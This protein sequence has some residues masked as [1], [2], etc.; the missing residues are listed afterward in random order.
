MPCIISYE[1]QSPNGLCFIIGGD[2]GNIPLSRSMP[3]A[4]R[5]R[6]L[7]RG[8]PTA[9]STSQRLVC[10]CSVFASS[11]SVAGTLRIGI[12]MTLTSPYG[13]S[14]VRTIPHRIRTHLT[15]WTWVQFLLSFST[16]ENGPLRVLFIG[17][18]GGNR[19]HVQ[20]YFRKNFSE[21]S[22][23]FDFACKAS[24]GRLDADYPVSSSYVN[25]RSRKR[26][27]A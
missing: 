6:V 5:W 10:I 14:I 16:N 8:F 26:F 19:T 4:R 7:D 23:V 17:G 21:R 25:G 13:L 2:G 27:P 9:I 3:A 24:H 12:S 20:E 11:S 18:D 15:P 22:R 1:K